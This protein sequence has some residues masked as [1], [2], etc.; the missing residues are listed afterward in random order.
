MSAPHGREN[1][2]APE[3][4]SG[5][6]P[7]E[8]KGLEIFEKSAGTLGNGYTVTATRV[9]A[10]QRRG[11]LREKTNPQW[12]DSFRVENMGMNMMRVFVSYA[13]EDAGIVRDLKQALHDRH[14]E[15]HS[16]LDFAGGE[17]SP[18]KVEQASADAD[19]FVFLLEPGSHA[20]PRLQSEW[21][22][23]LRNDWDGKRPMIPVLLHGDGVADIPRFLANRDALVTP[24]LEQI[25]E[26]IERV[27]RNPEEGRRR[28]PSARA[29][30]EWAQRLEELQSFGLALKEEARLDLERDVSVKREL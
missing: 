1:V 17:T 20:E 14:I 2:E 30:A 7:S 15:L 11:G 12:Q 27:V 5:E 19:A 10:N 4:F 13:K 24:N 22:A 21:R 6:Q 9:E 23:L 16:M 26:K 28:K 8:E 18:D 3:M 29:K 25:V